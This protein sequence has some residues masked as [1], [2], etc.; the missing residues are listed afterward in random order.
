MNKLKVTRIATLTGIFGLL[1]LII[2]W[3]LN[4]TKLDLSS[5]SFVLLLGG[6]PLLLGLP[7]ILKQKPFTHAWM[8]MVALLYFIHG[9]VEVW[10]QPDNKL[11]A[12]LEIILSVLLYFGA[13]FY[14]R[15]RSR[16]IKALV[17]TE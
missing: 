11:F 13:S 6:L 3:S 15:Y 14:A 16:E 2:Y 7:G 4:P 9:V 10:S 1:I 8:S 12:S 17:E 5:T